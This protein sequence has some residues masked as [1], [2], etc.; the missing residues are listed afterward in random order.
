MHTRAGGTFRAG[1]K[2][3][4]SANQTIEQEALVA[5]LEYFR[6]AAHNPESR[7]LD[8]QSNTRP[9]G[10]FHRHYSTQRA[11]GGAA[12]ERQADKHEIH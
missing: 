3:A 6:P 9:A 11:Q 8:C 2:Y 10:L 5:P 1:R 4:S 12:L 7:C